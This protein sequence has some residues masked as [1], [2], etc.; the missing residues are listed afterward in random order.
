MSKKNID[1]TKA[2]SGTEALQML[3]KADFDVVVLD[4]K[5]QEAVQSGR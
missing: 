4:L 3:R 5:I 1:V 2:Y